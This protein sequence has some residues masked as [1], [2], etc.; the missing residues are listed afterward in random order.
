MPVWYQFYYLPRHGS[1]NLSTA[2]YEER[3]GMAG[4]WTEHAAETFGDFRD[5]EKLSSAK[6]RMFETDEASLRALLMEVFGP[7]PASIH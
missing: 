4:A 5:T 3:D 7:P 2:S 1:K 6:T